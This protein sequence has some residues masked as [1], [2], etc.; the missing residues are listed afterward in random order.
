[1]KVSTGDNFVG[2]IQGLSR[3]GSRA[4]IGWPLLELRYQAC[5]SVR[6]MMSPGIAYKLLVW[7]PLMVESVLMENMA[8]LARDVGSAA[9]SSLATS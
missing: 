8:R 6:R 7:L 1:M 2:E 5:V 3:V 4:S 9:D